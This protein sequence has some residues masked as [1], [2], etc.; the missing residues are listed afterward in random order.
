MKSR[1]RFLQRIGRGQRKKEPN[2][3]QVHDYYLKGVRYIHTHFLKRLKSFTEYYPEAKV[4][5]KK[6]GEEE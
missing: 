4:I 1:N 3:L 2:L 5:Y 6:S